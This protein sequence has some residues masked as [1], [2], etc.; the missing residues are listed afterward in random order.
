MSREEPLVVEMVYLYEKENAK[1]HHTINYELVHL[2]PP[3]AVLRRGQS[4]HIALRFN[5][6]YI[7]EIDIVRLLF[8]F[9]PNPNVLRG[10]RGV[11]TITNRDS[12]L[13]DLEAWGVRLIGVSGVDLSAEVRSP[14]DSPVGMWQLNIETTIVGS[15]RSPNTY[16]YDKDIY[17]LF[18]PW[19]KEDLVYM[20]DEQLLDEYILNDVGKIWVGAWGSARGREWIFGQF[21]AYVLKACQL[22]LERSGIKA[23]SRGDPIQ[24]CRA[25]SRIVNSNDDKGVVTGRWDGDYQDG[26]APAAWTGSVPILEQF[27]ETGESVKYGQCWV[28]AGVV[29]TVCRALGI[30]SRVVS[31]LVSA[32]DANASLSVDRYY[33]KENEELEYDP[34]N[35]EG[36]DS[37]WNYHVWN[38]VWMARPDLPKG[39]G[40]WQAIDS[41]PQEPSE[42]V[43]QCGPASVEAIKQG[44]VGY[45]YDVTFMLASV[46]ADLMRWI[47][48]PDSEMGFRKIDCNKYHIG[49]MILTK[50]PWVYDPNGDRDR[51]DIT[52]LYKAKEG[53]ELERLTLYRAVRSTELAKRFYSLPSPAKED[54][55]FDLMDIERV[56][57]GEP[58]A[59]I[60]NIKNKSNEKRTIQAILSAGSVYYKGIK[61][62]LVKRASGDFVLE[63][64]ASEQL[65]LT[66]TVDDYLD[67][68]V[69][70]CNMKLYSIATVVETKQTWADEDDFQV[71][72]P[73]IVVKIDGEPTVGKPSII[74]LRFKNPLQRVLTDCKFNYAGPGLTR[75]KTLAFR[76]VDPEEDVYVEHQL[77]PQKAGSQKIIA[78][79]TSKELVD[80]TGSAVIDVLDMD[81]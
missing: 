43:Y 23:N 8:S 37:I 77:I 29:T 12:Y 68:L 10:T 17:L 28:F 69:E 30:P 58:F 80:V 64:Y 39:Y 21:D 72:K 32:H 46:N 33:S 11:N 36:E 26:T 54:V 56:N 14:V 73:N 57:I 22:L 35:V 62:Y 71:L 24:M 66:I 70:Y 4:F 60:V 44:V 3:A 52:S 6:E 61:A 40:G 19:L 75:N 51:E 31:N 47:E 15:K 18:N 2:D 63:P 25:I 9:G 45:N 76:D 20:E 34:N 65:R 41:T 67:K 16:N 1:L 50:A 48:D 74:S 53:T 38:D 27:L 5:R 42:G 7:D 13:T 79:F 78:T 81:E 59:V 49:R 55:E